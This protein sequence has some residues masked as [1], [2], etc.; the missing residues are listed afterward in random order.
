MTINPEA[1]KPVGAPRPTP[2]TN[3]VAALATAQSD[4]DKR[5]DAQIAAYRAYGFGDTTNDVQLSDQ[6][7]S[8]VDSLA[9]LP[10]GLLI[11]YAG[12][13]K[14]TTAKRLIERLTYNLHPLVAG[15]T[16]LNSLAHLWMPSNPLPFAIVA[17]TGMATKQ[18]RRAVSNDD[19]SKPIANHCYTIHKLLD[20]GPVMEEYYNEETKQY[21]ERELMRPRMHKNNKL[22]LKVVVV[23]EVSMVDTNLFE[24]LIAALPDDC[25]IYGIG[26]IA[27]LTPVFGTP[28]MPYML[29]DWQVH[30]LT[31]IYRQEDGSIINNANEIRS[32]R[33][34]TFSPNFQGLTLDK[35]AKIAQAQIVQTITQAHHNGEY[36]PSKD[37]I[38]T[39]TN[40]N[41]T[42][43]EIINTLLRPVLNPDNKLHIIKTMRSQ[44]R[45]AVGDRVMC[46][47]NDAS[48]GIY[49]GMLGNIIDIVPN[50]K[51]WKHI[52][53][54]DMDSIAAGEINVSMITDE[55]IAKQK[56]DK[57][58]NKLNSMFGA[59]VANR[60]AGVDK[61]E[62]V[63]EDD[64][65]KTRQATHEVIV[66]FDDQPEPVILSTSSRIENLIPAWV[67][68]T[69][70]AQGSGFRHVYFILHNEGG[71]LLTNELLYTGVTRCVDKIT[72]LATKYAFN[73]CLSN[74]T[75]E[76]V[77]LDEKVNNYMAKN[78]DKQININLKQ[79]GTGHVFS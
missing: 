66:Q 46:V 75:I 77:T 43:Q 72:V 3:A 40:V 4:T 34:P 1:H 2:N 33:K 44:K 7:Q 36:D 19:P 18:I 16:R 32:R 23:D 69:H 57:L 74:Q 53:K 25:R 78:I 65:T 39:T 55:I 9:Q 47:K 54:Q 26:D 30:E 21:S 27:Q 12:T 41:S 76:G 13:G 71:K 37:I 50:P 51:M 24:E 67:V 15:D 6:Q 70:K 29:R 31:K 64:G 38:L 73:K 49:N 45:L 42:G 22:P 62:E 17:F 79:I 35:D 52:E 28:I 59:D 58:A 56:A 20:Y 63:E 14:T 10:S 11:G 68:T 5:T 61:F 60:M 48:L 8:A